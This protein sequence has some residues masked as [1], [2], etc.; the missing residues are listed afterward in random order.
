VTVS[1]RRA[2]HGLVWSLPVAVADWSEADGAPDVQVREAAVPPAPADASWAGPL[3]AVR[4]GAVWFEFPG[5]ARA[6]V[7]AGSVSVEPR[8]GADDTALGSFLTGPIASI[9]LHQ[10]GVLPLRASA[11]VA[12]GRG[13]LITGVPGAGVSSL[14]AGLISRGAHG[15]TD[16]LA[17]VSAPVGS[18]ASVAP[19]SAVMS[20][21][22]ESA[23][24]LGLEVQACPRVR[25]GLERFALPLA[26]RW[27][28]PVPV[29]VVYLLR[30]WNLPEVRLSEVRPG[31]RIAALLDHTAQAM[32]VKRM[33]LHGQHF[34]LVAALA[35]GARMVEVRRTDDVTRGELADRVLEDLAP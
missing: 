16:G 3:R 9:V 6:H 10:R 27:G 7:A 19:G 29:E 32:T 11:A 26:P 18:P 33:G 15:V 2:A 13:A 12:S 4:D 28:E 22:R 5:V 23:D 31:D 20:L 30:S 8:P 17:A 25:P 21:W 34:A 14:L 24:S 35:A 1:F